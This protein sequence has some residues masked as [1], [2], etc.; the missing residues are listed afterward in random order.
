MR[1]EWTKEEQLDE[2][3]VR[4][5]SYRMEADQQEEPSQG[6]SQEAVDEIAA[7]LDDAASENAKWKKKRTR[8]VLPKLLL[9]AL[10][11]VSLMGAGWSMMNSGKKPGNSA[12]FDGSVSFDADE[13]FDKEAGGDVEYN[14]YG[15]AE[16]S[17]PRY[18]KDSSHLKIQLS[19]PGKSGSRYAMEPV[20]VYQEVSSSA[21][22]LLTYADGVISSGSGMVL[23][24]DGYILTCYHVVDD[25]EECRVLLSDGSEYAAQLVGG[26]VHTDLAVLKINAKNLKPVTFCDS[27][28]LMVGEAAYAVGDPQGLIYR[29]SFSSGI[30]SG[31]NRDTTVNGQAMTLHQITTPVNSG[32]SGGPVFNR[33]GQ[34]IGVVNMKL[35]SSNGVSVDNMGFFIPSTTVKRVV[36]EIAENGSVERPVLGISCLSID[37]GTAHKGIPEGLMIQSMDPASDCVAKGL[38]PGDVIVSAN[39]EEVK[40]VNDFQKATAGLKPGDTVKLGVWRDENFAEE[41]SDQ[42]EESASA[43][44]S[45]FHFA[46]LGEIE[47]RLIGSD[48]LQD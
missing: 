36:E 46:Y 7:L 16:Y 9:A 20:E 30:I 18:E 19:E 13:E 21:V 48:D 34:A 14:P 43:E 8:S 29:G 35:G 37:W 15:R 24:A 23:T 47:I 32:N 27:D 17:L 33:F 5:F 25:R 38:R 41:R 3:E 10:L 26:D 2:G 22:S 42:G 40:T 11:A 12:W 1:E 39:G 28:R 31:L 4:F 6:I 45:D 44:D